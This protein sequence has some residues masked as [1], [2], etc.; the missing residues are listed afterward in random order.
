MVNA[1]TKRTWQNYPDQPFD[2]DT[3]T[4]TAT[5]GN[6]TDALPD[7]W[8][9]TFPLRSGESS[10]PIEMPMVEGVYPY[11]C[12]LHP[13]WANGTVIVRDGWLIT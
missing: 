3:I 10:E 13:N 12:V 1:R 5:S 11:F 6:A 2:P 4:H 7:G 9:L 8:F